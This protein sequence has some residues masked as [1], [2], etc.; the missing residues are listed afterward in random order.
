MRPPHQSFALLQKVL[1][2][3][4]VL[5][6]Y[7]CFFANSVM[8]IRLQCRHYLAKQMHRGNH[9]ASKVSNQ[10]P[11]LHAASQVLLIVEGMF[12]CDAAVG[13]SILA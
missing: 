7:R 1:Q 3:H 6:L 9:D 12:F 13:P 10:L 4:H 5:D 2:T 8:L 11:S